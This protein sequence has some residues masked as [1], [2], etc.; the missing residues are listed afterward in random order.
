MQLSPPALYELDLTRY[1]KS[2]GFFLRDRA[3]VMSDP[4]VASSKGHP[5]PSR[6]RW[7]LGREA[8]VP[9]ELSRNVLT[10]HRWRYA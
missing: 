1:R 9:G 10:L 7:R 8:G 2:G 6:E 3:Y 5:C 4:Y